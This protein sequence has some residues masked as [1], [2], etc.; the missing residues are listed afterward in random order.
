MPSASVDV[1]FAGRSGL[2]RV[3]RDVA[4]CRVPYPLIP[5][6]KNLAESDPHLTNSHELAV[7]RQQLGIVLGMCRPSAMPIVATSRDCANTFHIPNG[8]G[9]E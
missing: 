9:F 4:A 3:R 5:Q 8:I 2:G 6:I 1:R 7:R